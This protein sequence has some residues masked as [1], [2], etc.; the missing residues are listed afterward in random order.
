ML[1]TQHYTVRA[2]MPHS[3]RPATRRSF[4]FRHVFA[5]LAGAAV[6]GS[7]FSTATLAEGISHDTPSFDHDTGSAEHLAPAQTH[8]SDSLMTD[9]DD[10]LGFASSPQQELPQWDFDSAKM[11]EAFMP[12]PSDPLMQHIVYVADEHAADWERHPGGK[13]HKRSEEDEPGP[14]RVVRRAAGCPSGT[15]FKVLPKDIQEGNPFSLSIANIPAVGVDF[16]DGSPNWFGFWNASF[17]EINNG[18]TT[19]LTTVSDVPLATTGVGF[20][21]CFPTVNAADLIA[22]LTLS[23][24]LTPSV[25]SKYFVQ[26]TASPG[27]ASTQVPVR[28]TSVGFLWSFG[29][30][31]ANYR[32]L[33]TRV[34]AILH[35]LRRLTSSRQVQSTHPQLASSRLLQPRA[36]APSSQA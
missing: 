18:Q 26:M 5:L 12:S 27:L 10:E 32:Q 11:R 9:E 14:N 7:H 2:R 4:G 34:F 29:E 16:G 36:S 1:T 35:F 20:S 21:G 6:A 17:V 13:L 24:S 31:F 22:T 8:L 23:G 19:T 3:Q 30:E 25:T 33:L 28:V 15:T